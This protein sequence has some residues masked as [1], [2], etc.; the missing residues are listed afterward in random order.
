MTNKCDFGITTS[1]ICF[2]ASLCTF[3]LGLVYLILRIAYLKVE[4]GGCGFLEPADCNRDWR[5]VFTLN[6]FILLDVW[7]PVILGGIG[8][9]IHLKDLKF[10]YV[11]NYAQYALFMLVT[12]LFA[13]VGYVGQ[14]GIIIAVLSATGALL[15]SIASLIGESTLKTL[16][17]GLKS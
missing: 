12:S 1:A 17:L 13:N 16:D 11:S 14:L 7:T 8:V 9:C 3:C 2:V 6:P 10:P 5:T 15:C 4:F